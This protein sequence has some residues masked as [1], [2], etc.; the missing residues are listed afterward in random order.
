MR[1]P[2]LT[3]TTTTVPTW[4]VYKQFNMR[5]RFDK[6]SYSAPILFPCLDTVHFLPQQLPP[7]ALP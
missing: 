7:S 1:V 6:K 2:S 4:P 5:M 3:L